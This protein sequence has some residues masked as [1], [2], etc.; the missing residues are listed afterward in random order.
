MDDKIEHQRKHFESVSNTYYR[1]R[2]DIKH[3]LFKEMLW[4]WFF[5]KNRTQFTKNHYSVLEPMC[6]YGEGFDVLNKYLNISFDYTG[7]DYSSELVRIVNDNHPKRNITVGNILNYS[8][9]QTYDLIILIGGLHHVYAQ[10][11]LALKNVAS[12]LSE[13]GIFIT[14]EPTHNNFLFKKVRDV[15]YKR[16]PLF[17]SETEQA[18][19]LKELDCLFMNSGLNLIDQTY[20]GLLGYV[21]YYN[22]DA[23]P[24]LNIGTTTCLK[25]LFKLEKHFFTSLLAKYLSFATLSLWRK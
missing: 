20:P 3:L 8:S 16:N 12:L 13:E 4:T 9:Q 5:G 2:Q 10:K 24:S 22:P 21:M 15:I 6:G 25:H 11:E 7:F 19:E 23:F 18:F 1:S 17:D 14:F